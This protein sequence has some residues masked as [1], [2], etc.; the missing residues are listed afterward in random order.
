MTRLSLL[1]AIVFPRRVRS[2]RPDT[3]N[4]ARSRA[5]RGVWVGLGAVAAA[6]IGLAAAVETRRPHWRDPDF[7]HRLPLVPVAPADQPLVVALGSSRTQMGFCPEAMGLRDAT[8]VNFGMAGAGPYHHRLTLERLTARGVHPDILLVEIMPVAMTQDSGADP[9]FL[10]DVARLSAADVE[11]LA[12]YCDHPD[13]LWKAWAWNRANSWHSLRLILMS[14]TRPGMLPWQARQDFRWRDMDRFGWLPYPFETV[15]DPERQKGLA[16][17]KAQC[18]AA[19]ARFHIAPGPDRALRD[20][21]AEAG[22]RHIRVG[23]YLMPE[24]PVYRSWYPP[25]ARG[26]LAEYLAGLSAELGVPV[27]DATDWLPEGSFADGHHMLKSG[28]KAFSKRFAAESLT[29]WIDANR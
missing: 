22:R 12:P 18:H 8:V 27:V 21:I 2:A 25:R 10:P 15:P 14:H 29:P 24:S 6:H 9:A 4:R 16:R 28:A 23:L 26:L 19:L 20:L 5:R 7:G 11:T 1:R 13:R 3:G 17:A